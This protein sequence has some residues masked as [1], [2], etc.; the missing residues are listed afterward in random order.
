MDKIIQNSWCSN[1]RRKN[2]VDFK[3]PTLQNSAINNSNEHARKSWAGWVVNAYAYFEIKTKQSEVEKKD[4]SESEMIE[5][6]LCYLLI[7]LEK[8]LDFERCEEMMSQNS[9]LYTKVSLGY[10]QSLRRNL[11]RNDIVNCDVESFENIFKDFWLWNMHDKTS[12]WWSIKRTCT[13]H[14]QGKTILLNL[15]IL[16]LIWKGTIF[17]RL[18]TQLKFCHGIHFDEF[19]TPLLQLRG[20]YRLGWTCTI[21]VYSNDFAT[22]I[23][24]NQHFH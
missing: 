13:N 6:E 24:L 5:Q 20:N 11:G 9:I 14:H 3:I 23:S 7:L 2:S 4:W 8:I 18:I 1:D 12:I 17:F 15:A 19:C 22:K 10:S 21:L 16:C